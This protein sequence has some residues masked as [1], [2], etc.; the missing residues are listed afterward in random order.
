MCVQLQLTIKCTSFT[1][2]RRLK[3]G[4]TGRVAMT[5]DEQIHFFAEDNSKNIN[6]V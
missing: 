2:F 3:G 4:Y 5:A 6:F 1:T